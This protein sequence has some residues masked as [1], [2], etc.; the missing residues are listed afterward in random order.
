[1]HQQPIQCTFLSIRDI[2][3]PPVFLAKAP[4]TRGRS[5]SV[6]AY[7]TRPFTGLR[8]NQYPVAGPRLH[9]LHRSNA[10]ALEAKAQVAGEPSAAQSA[11]GFFSIVRVVAVSRRTRRV[12]LGIAPPMSVRLS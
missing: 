11:T 7:F 12:V 2:E 5:G 1:M 4:A 6:S 10:L 8:P 9:A 3:K